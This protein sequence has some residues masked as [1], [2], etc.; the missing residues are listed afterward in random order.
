[1]SFLDLFEKSASSFPEKIA[2][3]D[4]NG[5]ISFG[6]LSRAVKAFAQ[7]LSTQGISKGQ[8]VA[9]LLGNSIHYVISY[10]GIMKAGA[11]AVPLNTDNTKKN[12][13][14]ILDSCRPRVLV[15][16]KRFAKKYALRAIKDI[17][18]IF[19][20]EVSA[21]RPSKS[22]P[23]S[24][25]DFRELAC[26]IYTSGTTGRPKGVMLSHGNIASNTKSIIS[27]LRLSSEDSIVSV[28]PF[29][30]SYGSSILH[31]HLAAGARIYIEDNFIY[32]NKVLEKMSHEEVTGFAGVPSTFAMLL[33]RSNFSDMNWSHLRYV[34]QAG[35]PMPPAVTRQLKEVLP[36]TDIFIMYGQ[37]EA[38][39]R[40]SYLRPELL[41]EKEGSVGKAIPGVE[42]RVV[43]KNGDEVAPGETGEI[44]ARGGNIMLGYWGQ[45]EETAKVLKDG[46][47]YTGDL[48]TV[49]EEGFIYIKSRKSELIKSG[50]HRISPKE[51][52]EV[53]SEFD[54]VAEVAV[55]GLPDRIL[56]ERIA[57][58]VVSQNGHRINEKGLLRHCRKNLA[59]FKVPHRIILVDALPKTSSG[60]IKKFL[61]REK[62]DEDLQEMHFK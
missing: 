37:T 32:P 52:E 30:Y 15:T 45:P 43:K 35:G 53:I 44:V 58:F 29:F 9:I 51:I 49:D 57:A 16:N 2:L 1:M 5:S 34:T 10:L 46:W 42:L 54:N 55:V 13:R 27:Y 59:S 28:L 21:E 40:L 14:Y 47:L 6:D 12:I 19:T 33:H 24:E 18:L 25:P 48:A 39:A 36:D 26:I 7:K 22:G 11:A 4:R 23:F 38:T 56:G 31:T 20:D 61:L 60:K 62:L 41:F 8:R 50:A 3:E 17:S